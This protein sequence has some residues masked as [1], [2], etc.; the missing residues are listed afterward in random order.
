M[1]TITKWVAYIEAHSGVQESEVL[2][3]EIQVTETPKRFK[4][5]QGDQRALRALHYKDTVN[6]SANNCLYDTHLEAMSSLRYKMQATEAMARG[7]HERA[8]ETRKLV[9]D[10]FDALTPSN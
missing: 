9:E 7:K 2:C 10:A 3:F 8:L 6:K 4:L 5:L 1:S